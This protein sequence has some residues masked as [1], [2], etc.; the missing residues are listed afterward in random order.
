MFDRLYFSIDSP[1]DFIKA[2]P[3]NPNIEVEKLFNVAER[4]LPLINNSW[5][6]ESDLDCYRVKTS[7]GTTAAMR[8]LLLNYDTGTTGDVV[9]LSVEV[10]NIS[11]A[12]VKLEVNGEEVQSQKNG[13]WEILKMTYILKTDTYCKAYFGLWSTDIGEFRVRNFSAVVHTKKGVSGIKRNTNTTIDFSVIKFAT[14]NMV[15]SG[16]L[17]KT[18]IANLLWGDSMHY[19]SLGSKLYPE[20]FIS[21]PE[22]VCSNIGVNGGFVASYY[23]PNSDNDYKCKNTPTVEIHRPVKDTTEKVFSVS[24]IAIGRWK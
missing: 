22:V 2:V 15:I 24:Y 18:G 23:S 6:Y 12:K 10:F 9:E 1:K 17:T 16:Y 8:M 20:S 4:S 3:Q 5:A 11:G 19:I 7:N 14:G 13:E 21:P